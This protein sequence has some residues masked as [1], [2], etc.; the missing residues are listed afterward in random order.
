MSQLES[1][2]MGKGVICGVTAGP[3]AR[4]VPIS[5]FDFCLHTALLLN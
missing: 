3:N 1:S 5:R 2:F 4:C